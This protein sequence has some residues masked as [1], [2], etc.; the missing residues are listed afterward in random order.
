MK[1]IIINSLASEKEKFNRGKLFELYKSNPIPQEERISNAGLFLKRQ[2]LSKILFFNEIYRHIVDIHGVIME[3]GC[4]W[5]QNLVTLT[6]MRG[7]Y[8]PFNYNRKIIGFDTFQGLENI[9][10]K[11]GSN[12]IIEEGNFSVTK[13]YDLF[14]EQL[15]KTHENES[16]LNHIEKNQIF[17]GDAVKTLNSYLKKNP[18]TLIAFA[19]FDFDIYTPTSECLK[20]IK[21]YLSKGAIV[22]F[23]ELND[24]KFP[25][26]TLA[27]RDFCDLNSLKIQRNRYSGMQSY[28]IWE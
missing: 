5:G 18:Q 8:E 15:L 1:D 4:R 28:F 26:E 11:D 24:P 23:D 27:L 17:K 9:S 19:W 14:L 6:N 2:E 20:L 3:F 10:E 12:E 13:D 25:G 22:G 16:P 7:I 21:P